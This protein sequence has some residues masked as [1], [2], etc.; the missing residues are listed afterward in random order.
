MDVDSD[1]HHLRRPY[2]DRQ[3][4]LAEVKAERGRSVEIA[5][6]VMHE[7]EAPEKRDAVVRPMPPPEGVI[8]KHDGD[9][10]LDPR[11]PPHQL[12]KTDMS[13]DD[14]CRE[15]LEQRSLQQWDERERDAA[16]RKVAH[17]ASKL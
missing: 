2:R 8:E 7:V 16:D 6:D 9:N 11:R 13:A 10:R 14:P 12:Q 5:V 15:R 3:R 4:Q 17:H 1:E